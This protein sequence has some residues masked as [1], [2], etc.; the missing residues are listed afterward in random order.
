MNVISCR[1]ETQLKLLIKL[2]AILIEMNVYYFVFVDE[3]RE[4]NLVLMLRYIKALT[5]IFS[6]FHLTSS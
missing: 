3:R 2:R 6:R 1:P 4:E 5:K